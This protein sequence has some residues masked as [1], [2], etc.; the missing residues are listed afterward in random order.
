MDQQNIPPQQQNKGGVFM[1]L[2]TVI[3]VR[4]SLNG[5]AILAFLIFMVSLI[6]I[7]IVNNIVSQ[8]TFIFILILSIIAMVVVFDSYTKLDDSL[9]KVKKIVKEIIYYEDGQV[10]EKEYEC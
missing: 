5:Y 10:E 8:I 4:D 1:D 2:E 6:G 3:E 9:P 7:G